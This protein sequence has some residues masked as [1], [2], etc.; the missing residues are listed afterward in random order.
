VAGT[1]THFNITKKSDSTL[2]GVYMLHCGKDIQTTVK[3]E[4]VIIEKKFSQPDDHML[5]CL[6]FNYE[7]FQ[8]WKKDGN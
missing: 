3:G 2:S 8:L 4:K 6:S 7:F 5:F 1:S